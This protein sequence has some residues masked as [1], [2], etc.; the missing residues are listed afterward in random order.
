VLA[1]ERIDDIHAIISRGIIH[2]DDLVWLVAL[3]QQ[4]L[5]RVNRSKPPGD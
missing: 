4:S 2:D 3:C 1:A 5:D